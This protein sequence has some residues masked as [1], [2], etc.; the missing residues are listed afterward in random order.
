VEVFEKIIQ[1]FGSK[2]IL[3]VGDLTLEEHLK[4]Q[5]VEISREGPIP[6]I[7]LRER[8]FY[9]GAAG[10]AAACLAA[11]GAKPHLVGLVG[12]DSNGKILIDELIKRNINIDGVFIHEN[13]MTSTH[14]RINSTREHQPTQEIVRIDTSTP[15]HISGNWQKKLLNIIKTKIEDIDAVLIVDKYS[16]LMNAAF[17][18]EILSLARAHSKETVGDSDKTRELFQGFD[19][20]V[21]NDQE[22]AVTTG[23]N[24]S[25]VESVEAAGEKLLTEL[26]NENVIITRGAAGMSVISN[27]GRAV[28]IPT[29]AQQIFDITGAGELV[30]AMIT[31]ALIS[32]A[33]ILEAARLANYAAGV[34]VSKPGLSPVSKSELLHQI[35]KESARYDAEKLV[36]LEQLKRII[37]ALKKQGKVIVWTNG[38]FDLMHVGHILYLQ[39]ARMQGD[40]LVVGLNSDSSVRESKGPTRPIVEE[41]QRAKLLAS[42]TCVDYVVLF[43]DKS[44]IGLIDYLRPDVYVKGGDYTIETIN[45]DERRLVEGFGGKICLMPGIE[46]MSTTNIIQK[47]L[48]NRE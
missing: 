18:K 3:V 31:L 16:N 6:V 9:P 14:I 8:T 30:S 1:N 4:G 32:Q 10:H 45:Q 47:I 40:V 17:V 7:E 29:E 33:S 25:D 26:T 22:A 37:E 11:L 35:R 23:I 43:S 36:D 20:L 21:C 5:M 28:H 15:A 38:C 44:P 2:E 46:G 24:I 34:S 12:H 42:L 48:N 39:R 27:N 19:V 13:L 41:S